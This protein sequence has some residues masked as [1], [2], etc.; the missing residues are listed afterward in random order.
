CFGV[1]V[2][3]KLIAILT[4]PLA[5]PV[6]FAEQ[7]DSPM[8]ERA[9]Y[10]TSRS[11]VVFAGTVLVLFA[12]NAF[13]VI[14]SMRSVD[15]L[16]IWRT[17]SGFIGSMVGQ[18][19]GHAGQGIPA[20]DTPLI[21][22]LFAMACVLLL[23][24]NVGYAFF[25]AATLVWWMYF[26]A[27][28]R[29]LVVP[30]FVLMMMAGVEAR[31]LV[32]RVVKRR[33]DRLAAPALLAPVL[34]AV[35]VVFMFSA[36]GVYGVRLRRFPDRAHV[37]STSNGHWIYSRKLV[38]VLRTYP[39]VLTSGWWQFPE[40][41]LRENMEFYDRTSPANANL[42]RQG[43][44]LFFDRGNTLSP[45]TSVRANCA[46]VLYTEGP[47]VVCAPKPNVALAFQPGTAAP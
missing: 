47:L 14:H 10:A 15:A 30:F 45:F 22:V 5:W 2:E 38:S 35:A 23:V 36:G 40:L 21:A 34:A 39:Y 33:S 3:S 19:Q 17:F 43:A 24:A 11:A 26:G 7:H 12:L 16:A 29:H 9:W 37:L 18:G 44:V 20:L 41:S 25:V 42:P 8:P 46:R 27:S 31:G 28:E 6:F 1:A 32:E 13:S 4:L